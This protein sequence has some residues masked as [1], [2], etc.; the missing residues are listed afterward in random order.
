MKVVR[1]KKVLGRT[2]EG[3]AGENRARQELRGEQFYDRVGA[4][5]L[6]G[7]GVVPDRKLLKG[8]PRTRRQ[9]EEYVKS[10]ADQFKYRPTLTTRALDPDRKVMELEFTAKYDSRMLGILIALNK[11]VSGRREKEVRCPNDIRQRIDALIREINKD[12]HFAN[13]NGEIIRENN[14]N[15]LG[16][17][18]GRFDVSSFPQFFEYNKKAISEEIEAAKRLPELKEELPRFK[19]LHK[20]LQETPRNRAELTP[21]QVRDLYLEIGKNWAIGSAK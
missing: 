4:L 17:L 20:A 2:P 10:N 1:G 11:K 8:I 6:R 7:Y 18:R 16:Q 14:A 15:F 12:P 9:L 19:A 13:Q 21:V 3:F 5:L